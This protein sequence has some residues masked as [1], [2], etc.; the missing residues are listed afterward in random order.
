[1]SITTEQKRK[2]TEVVSL[3]ET[4]KRAGDPAKVTLL[5]DWLRPDE[6]RYHQITYGMMQTTESGKLN[7]LLSMYVANNGKH[8][9]ALK[10]YL[11]RIGQFPSLYQDQA[12]LNMLK[13]AGLNDPI[14]RSTQ[15]AFFEQE[16]WKPAHDWFTANGFTNGLSMLV[17]FD[18]FIHSGSILPFLRKRFAAVT[19]AKGGSDQQWITEY[20]DTRHNW[21]ATHSDPILRKT[22]Y[23]T[24]CFIKLMAAGDWA[25]AGPIDANGTKVV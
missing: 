5:K 15:I 16:Y 14:M 24:A 4:S 20:V 2:I 21:L 7:K 10:P 13:D 1:M 12:L 17:I 6:Q 11:T 25:I 22:I 8:A 3:F 18:S 23:R 19:P 9:A